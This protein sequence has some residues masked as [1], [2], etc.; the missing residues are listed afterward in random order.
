MFLGCGLLCH[1]WLLYSL[2][3]L[4][5]HALTSLVFEVCLCHALAS[6]LPH[7]EIF[8][9]VLPLNSL[10]FSLSGS[11]LWYSHLGSFVPSCG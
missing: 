7:L 11:G 10:K 5:G 6:L 8:G 3:A 2:T 9:H 4:F 1:A